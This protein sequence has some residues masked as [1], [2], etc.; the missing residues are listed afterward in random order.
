MLKY[1]WDYLLISD[2]NSISLHVLFISWWGCKSTKDT[3]EP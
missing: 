2:L 1:W 3:K